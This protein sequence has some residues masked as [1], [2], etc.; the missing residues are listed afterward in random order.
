MKIGGRIRRYWK[1][2]EFAFRASVSV[3]SGVALMC[4]TV[5]FHALN[6]LGLTAG[7]SSAKCFP[8]KL[9]ERQIDLW[10]RTKSGDLFVFYE[11][12]L[13]RCYF[14]PKEL[15]GEVT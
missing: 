5:R 3:W 2:G 11:V 15:C 4:A 1:E 9:G 7:L 13:D 12:F 10:L 14:L 8:I 6:A